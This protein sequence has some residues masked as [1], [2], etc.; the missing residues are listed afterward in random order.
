M[1]NHSKFEG[2]FEAEDSALYRSPKEL[3]RIIQSLEREMREA[4]KDLEFETAADIRD[5][6]SFLRSKLY[7]AES[8]EAI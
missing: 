3:G 6:I 8:G 7:L 2:V 1:S 4:A 5:R